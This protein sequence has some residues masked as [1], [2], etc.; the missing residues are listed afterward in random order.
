[1]LAGYSV[2]GNPSLADALLYGQLAE[3]APGAGMGRAEPMGNKAAVDEVVAK[4]PKLQKILTTFG[5]SEG[6]VKWLVVRG[7]QN[8]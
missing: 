4:F 1:M 6:M 2:G 7:K 8:F 5:S 3:H